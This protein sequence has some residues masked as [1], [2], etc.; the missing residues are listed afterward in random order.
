M[1]AALVWFAVSFTAPGAM[2]YRAELVGP[3]GAVTR[4]V[5]RAVARPDASEITAR[6][7][8]ATEQAFVQV[9][10]GWRQGGYLVRVVSLYGGTIEKASN[11]LAVAAGT[12]DTLMLDAAALAWKWA[13]TFPCYL[14][15]TAN[16]VA[17][18]RASPSDS[19]R[20]VSAGRPLAGLGPVIHQEDVQ[21]ADLAA[22]CRSY[23]YTARRGV[24]DSL[25]CRAGPVAPEQ[26]PAPVADF[27]VA[28]SGYD[29]ASG[30]ASA[31]WRTI[32]RANLAPAGS[33]V[34]VAAGTYTE[35]P[36]AAGVRFVGV[37][38]A[39]ITPRVSLS[40][41][42]TVVQGMYLD[43]GL[44]FRGG[45]DRDSVIG[46]AIRKSLGFYASAIAP[47]LDPAVIRCAFDLDW[48]D[49][50]DGSGEDRNMTAPRVVRPVI[51]DCT[52]TITRRAGEPDRV[53]WRWS[54][55]SYPV[56]RRDTIRF[57]HESD[58]DSDNAASMKW[59]AVRYALIEDCRFT[60]DYT[61][62]FGG[63]GP[64]FPMWRDST[65][66]ATVLRT[67]WESVRGALYFSPNTAGT[68][69]CSCFGHAFDEITLRAPGVL[70]FYQCK[71]HGDRWA[72]STAYAGSFNVYNSGGV[73][74]GLTVK[75]Y[76]P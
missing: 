43:G 60:S 70:W 58:G 6:P 38:G 45:A 69:V 61:G 54:S 10:E 39:R 19:A 27:F 47:A 35:A 31:P 14:A 2:A 52:G 76:S 12:P 15:P 26:P 29:F 50:R 75:P 42:L 28:P 73:P 13:R 11:P 34:G 5:L 32:G 1:I 18:R 65:Y 63:T 20:V 59:L 7:A 24:R 21:R 72:R 74:P 8:G 9:P 68:W 71:L 22:L 30:S 16:C 62:T 51:E 53:L 3:G 25:W 56:L 67:T 17:F 44:E 49:G 36:S 4:T 55:V 23:G 48:I 40:K 66:G 37:P 46:C 57:V 64:F 33:T 41:S